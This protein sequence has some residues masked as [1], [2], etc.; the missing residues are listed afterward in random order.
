MLLN[1]A[2]SLGAFRLLATPLGE[3]QKDFN[4]NFYVSLAVT[5][6]LLPALERVMR[7]S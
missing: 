1:N 3:L 4:T 5:R 2:G 6:A 7:P